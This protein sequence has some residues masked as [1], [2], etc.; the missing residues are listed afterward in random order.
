MIAGSAGSG[1]YGGAVSVLF[2]NGDGTFQPAVN[3]E[4]G[5]A[6]VTLVAGDYN[7]DGLT[8]IAFTE[9]GGIGGT[10]AVAFGTGGGHFQQAE[11]YVA[12]NAPAQ[13][14]T[15]SFLGTG[16]ADILSVGNGSFEVFPSK[17]NGAF[18]KPT[19]ITVRS[20]YP[21]L[22][23]KGNF[24]GDDLP[25]VVIAGPAGFFGGPPS[26]FQVF[27]G[28]KGTTLQAGPLY[29]NL[30][31]GIASLVA[32][33]LTNDGLTDLVFVCDSPR[34]S[35][36]V[37]RGTG[38]GHFTFKG[39]VSSGVSAQV[40]AIG[41]FR[42]DGKADLVLA[43]QGAYILFGN[44][45]GTFGSPVTRTL[46]P[47]DVITAVA[48]ID[49]NGDG[50]LDV[51]LAGS[52]QLTASPGSAVCVLLGNGD[53]TFKKPACYPVGGGPSALAFADYNLDGTLDIA[54]ANVTGYAVSILLGAGDGTFVPGPSFAVGSDPTGIAAAD[55]NGDGK[56]DLV[57]PNSDTASFISVLL[58]S[59]K[60]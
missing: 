30:K 32:G 52:S 39:V 7:G 54:T 3:S 19:F 31:I 2:G 25:D 13:V 22:G 34:S 1:Q 9:T 12:G 6:V 16:D 42:G 53:G 41:D 35:Y 55:F 51:V 44:G 40:G 56:P 33:N 20:T 46:A 29:A 18:G 10:T 36:L 11:I 24:N 38:D 15:G 5:I 14:F 50:N 27:F 37:A 21:T 45:D 28:Q 47:N 58:N 48:A 60:P 43:G 49:L 26:G 23:V 4:L 17:G 59:T 8:D 57:T